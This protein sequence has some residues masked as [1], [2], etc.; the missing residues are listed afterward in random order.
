MLWISCTCPAYADHGKPCKHAARVQLHM[1]HIVGAALARLERARAGLEDPEEAQSNQAR[2]T[3]NQEE[4]E[5]A[6]AG[7][8]DGG[9]VRPAHTIDTAIDWP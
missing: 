4:Y 8:W 1:E 3:E 2:R 7:E 5:T 6:D 9:E